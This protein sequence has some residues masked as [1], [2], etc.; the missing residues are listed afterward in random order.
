MLVDHLQ[1]KGHTVDNSPNTKLSSEMYDM[2]LKEFA[3]EKLM[4]EKANQLAEK[5]KEEV[6]STVNPATSPPV[7]E[8]ET[9]REHISAEDLRNRIT[10][11]SRRRRSVGSETSSP[12]VSPPP[13]APPVVS[14]PVEE[15]EEEPVVSIPTA[16][17]TPSVKEETLVSPS[18]EPPVIKP[19][20]PPEE[21][22]TTPSG[23]EEEPVETKEEETPPSRLKV[24]GKIDLDALNRGKSTKKKAK[25]SE[26]AK[27][28]DSKKKSVPPVK[29]PIS[30]EPETKT[31]EPPVQETPK[32]SPETRFR[33]YSGNTCRSSC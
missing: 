10:P 28:S 15:K 23:E 21:T 27:G 13:V 4:K 2:L 17:E 18:P 19:P 24:V 1:E 7:A 11:R 5:R 22:S 32:T 16:E 12:V 9:E 14:P 3:S 31:P 29:E 33:N 8:E 20:T 26:K 6:R 30:S 25:G